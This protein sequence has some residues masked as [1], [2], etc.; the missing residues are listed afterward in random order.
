MSILADWQIRERGIVSPFAEQTREVDGEKVVSFGVSSF[1]YDARL[2]KSF[3][4]FDDED[5]GCLCPKTH[6]NCQSR[7]SAS[8]TGGEYQSDYVF[9]IQP[10]G[11]LLAHTVEHFK[12]PRNVSAICLGK[13]TYARLGLFVNCTPLEPEWEGQVTLELYNA[14]P[15][16]IRLWIGEGICQFQFFEGEQPQVSYKDRNGKYQGQTGVTLPRI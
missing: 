5:G 4:L 11:F 14:S 7:F 9:F 16:P 15:R 3:V 6:P 13:S 8:E 12:M 10:K 1:G 2:G